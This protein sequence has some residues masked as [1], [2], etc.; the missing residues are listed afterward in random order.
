M[1]KLVNEGNGPVI[2]WHSISC[3]CH[4]CKE[5]DLIASE[6]LAGRELDIR[7]GT[8]SYQWKPY[9]VMLDELYAN[10]TEG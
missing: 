7:I 4:D 6:R 9:S 5:F 10:N 3:V 2:D 8:Q 1:V